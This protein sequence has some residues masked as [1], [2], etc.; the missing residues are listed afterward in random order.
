VI[1]RSGGSVLLGAAV[2]SIEVDSSGAVTAVET[3]AR[4]EKPSQRIEARLVLANNA[5]DA[6]A[7]MLP[8]E[9]GQRFAAAF[10]GRPLSTS[11][12]SVHLGLKANPAQFGLTGYSTIHLPSWVTALSDYAKSAALLGANPAGKL[13]PFAIANYGAI[14]AR[15]DD[16]GPIL[17]SLAGTDDVSNWRG[18]SKDQERARRD[19]WLDAILEELERQ[20]PGFTGAVEQKVFLSAASMERYLGTP[21]GAVYGF[22]PIPPAQPLWRGMPRSPKTPVQGLYL[23][24]SWGGSG[25]FSGAMA[26]GSEAAGLAIAALSRKHG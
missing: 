12:F 6:I 22:D 1:K 2:A 23:A 9:A 21:D 3:A 15:L 24:S 10:A 8:E 11:L 18:L 16:G 14:D 4:G 25:G 7:R 17:V 20:Y 5:P 26:A 19:A 13:P